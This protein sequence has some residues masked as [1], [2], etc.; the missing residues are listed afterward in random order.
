MKLTLTHAADDV[1]ALALEPGGE[2]HAAR[3]AT[4]D[5]DAPVTVVLADDHPLFRRSMA[6]AIAG[7]P[8]L[9]LLAEAGDGHAALELVEALRP[10]VAVLDHRM[11]GLTGVEVCARL[12]DAAEPPAT[13]VL[14][15]S[16]FEDGEIVADAVRCG[17]A[18]YVGKTESRRQVCQAVVEV[19]RGGVA[20]TDRTVLGFNRATRRAARS[21]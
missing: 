21:G 1:A 13:A 20:F 7:H 5:D 8:G 11:P 6:R 14:L 15:L 4:L 12:N 18:G 3:L 10:D 9:R 16:A 19:G 17:A 2:P